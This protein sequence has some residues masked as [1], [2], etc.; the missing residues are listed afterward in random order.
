MASHPLRA[1]ESL[2]YWLKQRLTQR[3][4]LLL[5][6]VFVGLSAALAVVI[7]KYFAFRVFKFAQNLD[8]RLHFP[9]VNFFLPLLGIVLTVFIVNR[10]LGG[11]LQ[12]GT[13]RIIYAITKRSSILPRVQMYAQIIT[14]SVTVGFGG[15]AG[16][17]SPVTITGAAIGS[18]FARTYRLSAKERTLL[19]ACGVAA[20]IA[21]AFNAPIAGVLFT[22]EVLLADVGITAF[23]PL[24]LAAA[25][26][27]LLSSVL[28]GKEILLSFDNAPNFTILEIPFY[29][30]LGVIT[31]FIAVYHS[32]VFGFVE[33]RFEH[34]RLG[35]YSK[36]I[37]GALLL[38]LLI[39]ISPALFGE[40]YS[41]IRTLSSSNPDSFV[42]AQWLKDLPYPKLILIA[43]VVLTIL[44]KPF[45]TG[46]TL[47]SGGNGGN[48]APALFVGSLTGFVFAYALET[49]PFKLDLPIA[50]F[51]AVG[52]AGMLAG[53]FHAPL[54]AM[55]LIAEITGGYHLLV[56]LMLVSSIS[57]ALSKR[58]LIHS[59]DTQKLADEGLVMRADK[60]KHILNTL[61]NKDVL[62]E[63]VVVLAP[64]DT[65]SVLFST[66]QNTRQALFPI[67]SERGKL[68][69]M[70]YLDQLP[71]LIP[72]H[73]SDT[74]MRLDAVMEPIDTWVDPD[75]S[76]EKVMELMEKKSL[77]FIPIIT[78]DQV[79]GYYSKSKLLEAYRK[80]LV[81]NLVE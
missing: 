75:E 76:L 34:L 52:M 9:L 44:L 77:D 79:F 56:P 46:I 23:I 33:N 78:M 49:L 80:K 28:L 45:A 41:A 37:F 48:F 64:N 54:M 30:L 25:S 62:E 58:F 7:L 63:M 40:G 65:L 43:S 66:I 6:S 16:L 70:I 24:M 68:L 50:S 20:G 36:A 53:L 21:A 5:S 74:N 18:N 59:L 17:E 51:A 1:I 8:Q 29:I 10:V 22:V 73:T 42:S 39:L 14:S 3:Q 13:W 12:K 57:F 60:D 11:T 47:G 81:E 38:S 32:K 2:F 61:E 15:S 72:L 31:G 27:A 26:G 19:L 69:G 71:E 4:F 55:F 35:K 67:V